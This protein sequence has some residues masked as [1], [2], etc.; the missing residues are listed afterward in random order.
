MYIVVKYL[1]LGIDVNTR[2]VELQSSSIILSLGLFGKTKHNVLEDVREVKSFRLILVDTSTYDIVEVKRGCRLK[3]LNIGLKAC[4]GEKVASITSRGGFIEVNIVRELCFREVGDT[5][6][7]CVRHRGGEYSKY[8][9]VVFGYNTKEDKSIGLAM[10]PH[11]LY[12]LTPGINVIKVG[13][14]NMVKNIG[15][16]F[17]QVFI[18]ASPLCILDTVYHARRLEIALAKRRNVVERITLREKIA[19]LRNSVGELQRVL[20][21]FVTTLATDIIPV[22][23]DVLASKQ[24]KQYIPVLRFET[25]Y[26]MY[27]PSSIPILSPS[28]I[29][30]DTVLEVEDYAPGGIVLSRGSDRFFLPFDTIR[31][32]IIKLNVVS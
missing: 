14:A 3:F 25:R 9:R 31:D 19:K 21:N 28:D 18:Y 30:L 24:I 5:T 7:F 4:P 32:R 10:I 20:K 26:L 8:L 23:K 27:I 1:V 16:I 12:A 2:I 6:G 11:M 13:I 17:E 15:R 22:I 29:P